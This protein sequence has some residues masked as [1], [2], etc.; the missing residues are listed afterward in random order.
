MVSRAM[1]RNLSYYKPWKLLANPT[2]ATSSYLDTALISEWRL[3]RRTEESSSS[4]AD[5]FPFKNLLPEGFEYDDA[6][7]AHVSD[8]GSPLTFPIPPTI[9]SYSASN[10]ELQSSHIFLDQPTVSTARPLTQ[11]A[12]VEGKSVLTE[13]QSVPVSILKDEDVKWPTQK[14]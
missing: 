1:I 12:T 13:L 4:T 3:H 10:T 7:W 6:F 11:H 9:E 8:A 2:I 5:N 14:Q